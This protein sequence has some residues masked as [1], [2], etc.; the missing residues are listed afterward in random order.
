[1]QRVFSETMCFLLMYFGILSESKTYCMRLV[2]RGGNTD[3]RAASGATERTGKSDTFARVR[4][5]EGPS[6]ISAAWILRTN[7]GEGVYE[8]AEAT[9]SGGGSV[10]TSLIELGASPW[11]SGPG[12]TSSGAA[13]GDLRSSNGVLG[14]ERSAVGSFASQALSLLK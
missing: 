5:G 3:G 1:M 9:F 4:N 7:A 14:G 8:P 11:D 2:L 13:D 10:A 6:P 12:S